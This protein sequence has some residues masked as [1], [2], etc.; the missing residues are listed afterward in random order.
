LRCQGIDATQ[1]VLQESKR[2]GD[3]RSFGAAGDDARDASRG[4]TG[5][6]Y[7]GHRTRAQL[8]LL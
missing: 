2:I 6:I 1:R 3:E 7:T 8:L 4:A 5:H